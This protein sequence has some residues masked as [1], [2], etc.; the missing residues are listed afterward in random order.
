MLFSEVEKDKRRQILRAAARVFAARGYHQAKMAEI[1][2]E[3]GVGKGTLYEYFPS[4]KELF[5][6]MVSYLF[7]THSRYLKALCRS[8]LPLPVFLEQLFRDAI[9]F[10]HEHRHLAQILLTD[11]PL[12]GEEGLRFFWE[13]KEQIVGHLSQYARRKMEEG[14]IRPLDPRLAATII[15]HVLGALGYHLL[16][17]GELDQGESGERIEGLARGA[18]DVLLYGLGCS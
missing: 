8:D 6:Q 10:M 17:K 3:A 4:K 2:L 5:R 12:L 11:H 14:E 16:L 1:A 15:L 13:I 9:E 18:R 7:A